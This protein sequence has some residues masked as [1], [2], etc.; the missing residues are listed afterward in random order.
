[1]SYFK[2]KSMNKI[3]NDFDKNKLKRK[4]FKQMFVI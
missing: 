4:S 3:V 2:S 1:M